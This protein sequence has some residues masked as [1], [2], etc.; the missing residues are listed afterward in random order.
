[1]D[2]GEDCWLDVENYISSPY[3]EKSLTEAQ[4]KGYCIV[5]FKQVSDY[6]PVTKGNEKTELED[7]TPVLLPMKSKASGTSPDKNNNPIPGI[8]FKQWKVSYGGVTVWFN[9]EDLTLT[10]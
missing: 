5:A 4:E 3:W 10:Y 1:M 2:T 7:G 8:V 9:A 6:Y